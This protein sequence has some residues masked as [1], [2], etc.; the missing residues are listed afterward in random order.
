M[1]PFWNALLTGTPRGG[2]ELQPR[3]VRDNHPKLS[4]ATVAFFA[5][6][7]PLQGPAR[8][9]NFCGGDVSSQIE[10]LYAVLGPKAVRSMCESGS[11]NLWIL[12]E[13]SLGTRPTL[14][15]P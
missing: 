5:V 10:E 15:R 3:T 13:M 7:L 11:V 9:C 8:D 6:T 4:W 14:R 12:L 1:D 2:G